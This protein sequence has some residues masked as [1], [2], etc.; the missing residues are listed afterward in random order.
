MS[1]PYGL[2]PIDALDWFTHELENHIEVSTERLA[3]FMSS[4]NDIKNSSD[5]MKHLASMVV[6]S[7]KKMLADIDEQLALWLSLALTQKQQQAV[8]Y[9]QSLAFKLHHIQAMFEQND[10]M[11]EIRLQ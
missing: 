8:Q 10:P 2:L 5:E 7:Y 4:A 1:T 11:T 9:C 3:I 6:T